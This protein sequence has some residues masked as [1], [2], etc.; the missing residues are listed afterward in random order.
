MLAEPIKARE[1]HYPMIQFLITRDVRASAAQSHFAM[2]WSPVPRE[3]FQACALQIAR[4]GSNQ[5]SILSTHCIILIRRI[6]PTQLFHI[7]A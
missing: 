1:M 4:T 5:F 3:F 7:I 6:E 2:G